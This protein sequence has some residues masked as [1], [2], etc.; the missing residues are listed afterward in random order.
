MIVTPLNMTTEWVTLFTVIV[1][2][3]AVDS[4]VEILD[5]LVD[6]FKLYT[7]NEYIKKKIRCIKDLGF[8][9]TREE[10]ERVIRKHGLRGIPEPL[11]PLS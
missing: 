8:T 11:E 3:I 6:E 1:Y 7:T 9:K 10:G 2:S 4:Y 5:V